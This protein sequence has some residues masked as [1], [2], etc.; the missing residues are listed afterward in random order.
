MTRTV[1][2]VLTEAGELRHALRHARLRIAVRSLLLDDRAR[3]TLRSINPLHV[4]SLVSALADEE[5]AP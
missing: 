1:E 2:E 3:E 4:D 5:V